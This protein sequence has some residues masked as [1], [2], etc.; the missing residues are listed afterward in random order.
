[1]AI[2]LEPSEN[3]WKL[4]REGVGKDCRDPSILEREGEE[5]LLMASCEGGYKDV[6]RS[7]DTGVNWNEPF[8]PTARVWGNLRGRKGC[9][10]WSGFVTATNEDNKVILF[11]T[12]VYL[13][14][15]NKKEEEGR[16]NGLLHLWVTDGARVY[17]VGRI[18]DEAHNAT[19]S[20]L[21]HKSVEEL[22]LLYESATKSDGSHGLISLR[23]TEQLYRTREVVRRWKELDGSI[24]KCAPPSIDDSPNPTRER[25]VY[26]PPFEPINGLVGHLSGN[27][28][29][30]T[31]RDEHHCVNAT[32]HGTVTGTAKDVTFQRSWAEWHVGKK[33]G[34]TCRTTLRT[35]SS[36][37][38]RRCSSTRS[39]GQA[40]A[41]FP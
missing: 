14:D 38:W 19:A 15:A 17:D 39:R 20:F 28:S 13:E 8:H 29:D 10:V 2:T 36:L 9:G 32:V 27:F 23:L 6:Y 16:I 31:W 37:S 34:R 40:A 33:W 11:T 25:R 21:L 5:L 4:L 18:S 30:N 1:M 7:T 41:P 12:L 22:I 24:K 35:T 3:R 26:N